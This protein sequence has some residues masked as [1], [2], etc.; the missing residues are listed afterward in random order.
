[1]FFNLDFLEVP[2]EVKHLLG[3]DEGLSITAPTQLA[4]AMSEEVTKVNVEELPCFVFEHVI[5]WMTISDTQDIGCNSLASKRLKVM[6]MVVF[7]F[8]K[9]LCLGLG[10]LGYELFLRNSVNEVVHHAFFIVWAIVLP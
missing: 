5:A 8:S 7:Q 3:K 6:K 4:L 10:V 2:Q 9:E 1:M